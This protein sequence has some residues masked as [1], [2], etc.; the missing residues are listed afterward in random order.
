MS[1]ITPDWQEVFDDGVEAI[2]ETLRDILEDLSIESDLH[3][4]QRIQE[5]LDLCSDILRDRI[6]CELNIKHDFWDDGE[7][8]EDSS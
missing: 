8:E 2:R 1:D 3:D 5:R 4:I 6:S 7:D